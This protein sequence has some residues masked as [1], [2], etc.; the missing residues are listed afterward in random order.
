MKKDRKR[1]HML[2]ELFAAILI[3]LLIVIVIG[4]ISYG[5]HYLTK[6]NSSHKVS[7]NTSSKASDNTTT[8]LHHPST[9]KS[10][11]LT[12]PS[13]NSNNQLINTGPGYTEFVVF[14]AASFSGIL[15]HYIW[16]MKKRVDT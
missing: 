8:K 11:S 12:E 2:T 4:G 15:L 10:I 5:I 3:I 14:A 1:S 9:N 7:S 13:D 6:I 16:R